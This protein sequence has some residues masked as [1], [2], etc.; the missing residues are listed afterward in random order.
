MTE[1]KDE[2]RKDTR[3][4]SQGLHYLPSRFNAHTVTHDGLLLLYNSLTGHN[5][6]LPGN[7]AERAKVYLS[8]AGFH[9]ELDQLGEYLLAK[10][11]IVSKDSDEQAKWDLSYALQQY[12]P[13]VLQLTLLASE[14]CN[15][16]CIYCSQQ[17]KRGTMLP[18][19]RAGL[20]ALVAKRIKQLG[21]LAISWFGGEP[22]LGYEAIEE[23]APYMQRM[24]AE[25]DVH[26]MSDMTTNAY[27]LTPERSQKLVKWGVLTYQITI[28][29]TPS[30]HNARRPLKDGS[31]TFDRI[32]DNLRA[33]KS[34]DENFGVCLR[35]NFDRTNVHKLKAIFEEFKEHF[36]ADERFALRFRPVVRMGSENDDV[37]PICEMKEGIQH[38]LDLTNKVHD[39]GLASESIADKWLNPVGSV[40]YAA[41]PYHFVI[42][43]D[44]K[45]MKC[46]VLMDN[47]ERNVVGSLNPDGE[48]K[49][50][51]ELFAKWVRPYYHSD[52]R[53]SKCFY[54][55]VCQGVVC[56]A[57]RVLEGHRPCPSQQQN[58]RQALEFAMLEKTRAGQSRLVRIKAADGKPLPPQAPVSNSIAP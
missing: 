16:R 15:F 24:A 25:H 48:L 40:C 27:L 37:L 35:V 11:Y 49:I 58:I 22:L 52:T 51:F 30:D 13:D 46:T 6:A 2:C 50:D 23:L 56:A 20:K 31:P 21:S 12:R 57:P 41:R 17:Y 10:G 9:G 34:Y 8:K 36:G 26:F 53:C 7:S 42:G 33:M 5:C 28:D 1:E 55:P 39:M 54:V 14:D 32:M 18:A 29:G 43:A 4:S 3:A 47:D 44:G 19:V 38:V 45:V